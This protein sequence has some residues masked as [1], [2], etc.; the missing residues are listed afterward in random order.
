MKKFDTIGTEKV[1][2][3]RQRK[4]GSSSLDRL[5]TNENIY[6]YPGT[7]LTDNYIII[8]LIRDV[9]DKWRSGYRE[10]FSGE[11]YTT[12]CNKD[13]EIIDKKFH[14]ACKI[15]DYKNKNVGH[16]VQQLMAH[17]HSV[18]DKSEYLLTHDHAEFW[19]WNNECIESLIT[20]SQEKSIYFLELKDLSNPKFLKWLHNKDDDWKSVKKILHRNKTRDAFW[21]NSFSFW[22]DYSRGDILKDNVLWCPDWLVPGRAEGTFH[23]LLDSGPP[24][25]NN[26]KKSFPTSPRG[27]SLKG[28]ENRLLYN[29][30]KLEQD[31]VN[32]IRNHERYIKL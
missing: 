27:N 1:R 30:I 7:E 5:L 4:M 24:P 31:S 3:G 16:R 25:I 20:M 2:I 14:H 23:D 11:Y 26:V 12:F 29:I 6:L 22:K 10:E 32:F 13:D 19:N 15:L 9:V 28:F 21:V 17:I 18:G 8:V